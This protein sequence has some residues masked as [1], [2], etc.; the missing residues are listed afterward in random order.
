MCGSWL[1]TILHL[2]LTHRAR[3]VKYASGRSESRSLNAPAGHPC[4]QGV[5]E[6]EKCR[7]LNYSL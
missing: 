3:V 6:P 4:Y 7:H 5:E 2:G 1:E